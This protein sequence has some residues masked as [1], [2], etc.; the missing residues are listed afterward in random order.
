MLFLSFFFLL[1]LS[2]LT[3]SSS[4]QNKV[5]FPTSYSFIIPP[6][7]SSTLINSNIKRSFIR[8]LSSS[9]IFSSSS[10]IS[11][12]STLSPANEKLARKRSKHFEHNYI[13]YNPLLV[14]TKN[15]LI[16]KR[17]Y[18]EVEEINLGDGK[19]E[20]ENDPLFV[21]LLTLYEKF[22]QGEISNES[23]EKYIPK[24]GEEVEGEIISINETGAFIGIHFFF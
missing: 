23:L 21:Q 20:I 8:S 12:S 4:F 17:Y 18:N 9:S 2:I 1:F 3:S 24:I 14:K 7:S 19:E 11:S 6:L 13:T 10:F 16:N 22:E 15:D 5:S